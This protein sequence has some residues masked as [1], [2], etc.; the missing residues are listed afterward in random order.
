MDKKTYNEFVGQNFSHIP[1]YQEIVVDLETPLSVYL[2]LSNQNYSY[3]F[4]S[5]ESGEQW[6]RYSIIGL[7]ADTI[8]KV[9]DHQIIVENKGDI[10]INE[11]AADPLMWIQ[12][13][14][15]GYR[16][17]QLADLPYF[18]GGAV[19]YF[20]YETIQY[21]E[22]RLSKSNNK[23]ELNVP[24]ILLMISTELL[25]FDN[26]AHRGFLIIHNEPKHHSYEYAIARLE[27][28]AK[29]LNKAIKQPFNPLQA[30]L[31]F[32]SS[33]QQV[34]FEK[35][36]KRIKKYIVDGDVMQVVLSQRLICPFDASPISL[37]RA[38]RRLNP[39]P[40]LYFLHLGDFYIIGSSPEI[41]TRVKH[42][43]ATVRPLAGT[44]KRG[45]TPDEDQMLESD[46]LSD[47][48][49]RA[50][51]LML[52][53]LGRNDLGRI[54]QIGSV[55]VSEQM[56][57]ERYSHV[58]HIVSNVCCQLRDDVSVMDALKATFPAGT[59]SGA[60]KVRAMEIINELEPIKRNIYGGAIGYLTW[61][62]D[63]DLA[64][65][66][67]TAII[68]DQ[69]LFVQAGAGIVYDSDPRSEWLETMQKAKALMT[70]AQDLVF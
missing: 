23:N 52:I 36:V 27:H 22:S 5:V 13:F 65:A 60:P 25:V 31:Q 19:G 44:R 68:K 29:K 34:N 59:L 16:V 51:H 6:G 30:N 21:I 64:I 28:L 2:K 39:S 58:M 10:T 1:L 4:E 46:L 55:K 35:A 54:A 8:I 56:T 43:Q 24:D 9:F 20:G 37:Y 11:T 41:L 47:A 70:A 53:D 12:N 15:Q 69:H 45:K 57:I 38:L 40:Y 32:R 14:L 48:K 17:P 63:M 66:I 18:N 61:H 67:R 7:A 50:E 49:E 26:L 42:R 62:G 33:F 3:L